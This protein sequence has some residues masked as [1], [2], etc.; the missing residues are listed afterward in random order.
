M[1][2][3]KSMLDGKSCRFPMARGRKVQFARGKCWTAYCSN[4]IWFDALARIAECE[5][6]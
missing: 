4:P 3:L 1:L 2:I 6:E 5:K